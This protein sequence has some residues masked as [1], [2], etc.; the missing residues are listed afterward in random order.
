MIVYALQ[1]WI[2]KNYLSPQFKSF[3]PAMAKRYGFDFEVSE[4]M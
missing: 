4:T 1:F 2:I 3:L